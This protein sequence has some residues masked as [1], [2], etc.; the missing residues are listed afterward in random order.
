VLWAFLDIMAASV[1]IFIYLPLVKQS[2]A[3]RR[4]RG[5]VTFSFS[6]HVRIGQSAVKDKVS[7][8]QEFP[9]GGN[10]VMRILIPLVV[11]MAA[12]V[13][14][15]E[16]I[17]ACVAVETGVVRIVPTQEACTAQEAARSWGVIGAVGPQGPKGEPGEPGPAGAQ[18]AQG[19]PGPAGPAGTQGEPGPQGPPGVGDLGYSIDQIIKW[20]GSQ[21]VCAD[22]AAVP[23]SYLH[24]LLMSTKIAFVSYR[25]GNENIYVMHADGS[26]VIRLTASAALDRQPA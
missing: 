22:E 26:N 6:L 3:V 24:R 23:N 11:L 16:I 12:F 25:D 21:W 2:S 14:S 13:G 10:V 15:G 7:F 5:P 18:G 1:Q 17:H 8:E 9:K 20:A 19:V 4:S